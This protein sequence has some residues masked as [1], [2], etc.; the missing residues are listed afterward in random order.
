M[1]DI[2]PDLFRFMVFSLTLIFVIGAAVFS[3][4]GAGIKGQEMHES[5]WQV[6]KQGLRKFAIGVAILTQASSSWASW[7]SFCSS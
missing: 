1:F 5:Y 6:A 7:W 3:L 4:L 2:R